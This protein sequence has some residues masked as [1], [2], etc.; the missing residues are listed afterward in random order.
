MINLTK[1]HE[2][3]AIME[4]HYRTCPE[5]TQ[6]IEKLKQHV[7]FFISNRGAQL[8]I[9]YTIFLFLVKLLTPNR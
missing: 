2:V 7:S 9:C 1:S 3:Q 4:S 5:G 8:Y 6:H